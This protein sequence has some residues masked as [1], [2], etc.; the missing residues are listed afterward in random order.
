MIGLFRT[1]SRMEDLALFTRY[2]SGALA[3]RAPLP[4]ILRAYSKE[5]E[6]S[7]LSKAVDSIAD[8]A[9]SGVELSAA[10][11]D[12]PKVFPAS[13][14]RLVRLGEQGKS[15]GG[16]MN[17]QAAS[18]EEGLK[19]YEYF[20]RAAVYPMIV[21]ILLFLNICFLANMIVPKFYAIYTEL[22]AV[23]PGWLGVQGG[24]ST[25]IK[26]IAGA[27]LIPIGFLIAAVMGLRARGFGYGRFHLQ[28]PLIGPVLRKAE[29]ARFAN[30][31]A[32]LVHQKIPLAEALGLLADAAENSY[33][34]AAIQDFQRRFEAGEKLSDMIATQPLFPA[35]MAVMIAAAEDQGGLAETLEGLGKFYTERTSHGLTILREIFEPLMLL[36]IG[37]LVALI[38]VSLYLPLFQLPRQ[39][40]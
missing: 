8:R 33:V 31:L 30:N 29:T 9:E 12:Y 5:A 34:R 2:L 16:I 40:G 27:L 6:V 18:L 13:Y 19:T 25:M 32:L 4:D 20:R 23:M 7:A 39:V 26:L 28:F 21:M 37:L 22:G 11:E 24:V 3:S 38:M 10:M 1:P 36:L 17:R 35:S 15:L 14:R